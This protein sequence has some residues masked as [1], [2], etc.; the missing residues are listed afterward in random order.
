MK[1]KIRRIEVSS[2]EFIQEIERIIVVDEKIPAP[3]GYLGTTLKTVIQSLGIKEID[4]WG[5]AQRDKNTFKPKFCFYR[6]TFKGGNTLIYR[7]K[8]WESNFAEK[9]D[10]LKW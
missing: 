9:F 7:R 4:F 3:I 2:Q 5:I 1:I 6:E 10:E 8:V